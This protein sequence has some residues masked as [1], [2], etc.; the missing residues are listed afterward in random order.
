[1]A[2]AVFGVPTV[3]GKLPTGW[4]KEWEKRPEVP[5]YVFE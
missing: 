1:L 3:D 5:A 4:E 2:T